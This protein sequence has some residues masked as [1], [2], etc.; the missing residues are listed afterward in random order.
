ML[1]RL[2][3]AAATTAAIALAGGATAVATASPGASVDFG[4]CAYANDG[5]ASVPPGTPITV[6]DTGA[7]AEGNYGLALAS[8]NA[9]VAS[10][11]V[12]VTG[13]TTTTFP[14]SISPPQYVGDPYFAWLSFLPDIQLDP[15]A[16]GGSVLVT[17]D[18]THLHAGEAVYPKQQ[19]PAPHFGPFHIDPGTSETQC[20]I[21]AGD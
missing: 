4:A 12:A 17:I 6:T 8:F 10:A 2:I 14:L 19:Y 16:S 15:L 7:F 11:T 1:K 13:G 18:V 20:L 5:L 3:V 21:S 9:S